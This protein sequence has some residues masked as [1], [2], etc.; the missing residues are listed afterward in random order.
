MVIAAKYQ[1][2][3][4][5]DD[6][7]CNKTAPMDLRSIGAVIV[8]ASYLMRSSLLGRR[9]PVVDAQSSLRTITFAQKLRCAP[10]LHSHPSP[11]LR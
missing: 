11:L 8:I 3:E 7:F 6:I 4:L 5:E 9:C 2:S 1:L 10:F